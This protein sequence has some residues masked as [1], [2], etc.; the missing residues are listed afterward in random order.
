MASFPAETF[1]LTASGKKSSWGFFAFAISK[2]GFLSARLGSV[3]PE[4]VMGVGCASYGLVVEVALEAV[5]V[6]RGGTR[7][8]VM[9]SRCG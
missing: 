1:S 8:L 7:G 6:G 5:F 4:V 2:C 9:S 3:A